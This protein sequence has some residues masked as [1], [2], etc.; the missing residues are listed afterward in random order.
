MNKSLHKKT[1]NS[2]NYYECTAHSLTHF[3]DKNASFA[4]WLYHAIPV[5][6]NTARNKMHRAS[7]TITIPNERYAVRKTAW[8]I[9]QSQKHNVPAHQ[10]VLDILYTWKQAQENPEPKAIIL[11]L[12]MTDAPFGLVG[13]PKKK[14]HPMDIIISNTVYTKTSKHSLAQTATTLSHEVLQKSILRA[15][16]N[17]QDIEP[18]LADWF[19]GEKK[20][21]FHRTSLSVIKKLK[22]ELQDLKASFAIQKKTENIECIAISPEVYLQD[23]QHAHTIVTIE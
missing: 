3:A 10:Q 14:H 13:Q 4:S 23:L 1:K 17:I 8:L 15:K 20:I 22:K 7:H 19:F 9:E 2:P 6:K 5:Q 16:G 21:V 11:G 12:I 18:E